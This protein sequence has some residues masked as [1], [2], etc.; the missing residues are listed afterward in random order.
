MAVAPGVGTNEAMLQAVELL[1]PDFAG[2]LAA[3]DVDLEMQALLS[4]KQCK[5]LEL[6]SVMGDTPQD[7]KTWIT[8]ILEVDAAAPANFMRCA[9]VIVA[10][11]AA[12]RRKKLKDENEAEASAM[13]MNKL[14]PKIEMLD[15]RKKFERGS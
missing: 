15:L 6:F 12:R 10:W 13:G 1:D 8:Q 5:S 14:I 7:I 11:E 3:K 4:L 9:A 2:L